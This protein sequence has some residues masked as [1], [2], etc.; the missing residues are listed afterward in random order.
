MMKFA[1]IGEKFSEIYFA[2]LNNS[3]TLIINGIAPLLDIKQL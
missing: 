3:R 1:Y 2:A